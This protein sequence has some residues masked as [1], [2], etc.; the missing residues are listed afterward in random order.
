MHGVFHPLI[1]Q[2]YFKTSF[3]LDVVSVLYVR[4]A[5]VVGQSECYTYSSGWSDRCYPSSD[6]SVWMIY[7]LWLLRLII[8]KLWFA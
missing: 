8:C 7:Q 3:L 1:E 6:C 2:N 4:K 5:A